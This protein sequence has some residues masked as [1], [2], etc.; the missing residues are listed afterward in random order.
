MRLKD[1]LHSLF[2]TFINVAKNELLF[3]ESM[4]RGHT[5]C[6]TS[7]LCEIVK[8]SSTTELSDKKINEYVAL[9]HEHNNAMLCSRVEKI[10]RWVYYFALFYLQ[11]FG[12]FSMMRLH[13]SINVVL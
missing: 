9:E 1:F 8:V 7:T 13:V 6:G 11:K 2:F 10:I 12:G 4:S 3:F 5:S